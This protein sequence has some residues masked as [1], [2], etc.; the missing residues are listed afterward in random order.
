MPL[1]SIDGLESFWTPISPILFDVC[2]KSVEVEDS[3]ICK[4]P[5]QAQSPCTKLRLEMIRKNNVYKNNF[6]WKWFLKLCRNFKFLIKSSPS[7]SNINKT[8][9]SPLSCFSPSTGKTEEQQFFFFCF[10][11]WK[12]WLLFRWKTHFYFSFYSKICS[13][14]LLKLH[15]QYVVFLNC[16]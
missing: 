8:L 7:P 13:L 3:A 10:W 12:I 15:R 11:K 1:S 16:L 14:G 6:N 9:I 4:T 2:G 5:H